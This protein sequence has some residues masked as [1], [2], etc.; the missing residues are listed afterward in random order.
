MIVMARASY[1]RAI[2]WLAQND[3]NEWLKD[4]P[5]DQI[6]SVSASLVA[7]LFDKAD[8]QVARDLARRVKALN[9]G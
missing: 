6:L 5:A 1:R 4:E 3:D 9:R 7:D 8:A 2:D